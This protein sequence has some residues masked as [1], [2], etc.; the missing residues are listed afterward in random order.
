MRIAIV[1]HHLRPGG[2]TRVIESAVLSLQPKGHDIVVLVGEACPQSSP[3]ADH[4]RVV[5][6]L[7]YGASVTSQ[8]LSQRLKDAAGEVDCWHFHNH[9]LG[10]NVAL[11]DAIAAL[12]EDGTRI[13]LQ[14]HDFAEDGRPANYTVAAQSDVLYPS[15]EGVHYA[16]LTG[17]DRSILTY[18]GV[19][20]ERLHLL[21][22]PVMNSLPK[23]ISDDDKVKVGGRLFLYPTRGIRRKNIGEAVFLA[24]LLKGEGVQIATSRAPL[25]PV[26]L[27]THQ[28]W[29]QFASER[30]LPIAFAVVDNPAHGEHSYESW[31]S[32]A[33]GILTTSIAEGFGLAFLEPLLLE[34]PVIGRDLLEVTT[35]FRKVGLKM[36]GLYQ[37]LLVPEGWVD[38][39]AVRDRLQELL[40]PH[41]AAYGMKF[42][43]SMVAR[44]FE[45]IS[46]LSR[47][48]DFGALE[49]PFQEAVIQQ[50]VDDPESVDDVRTMDVD[51]VLSPAI[52]WLRKRM[53]MG[54]DLTATTRSILDGVFSLASYSDQLD[55]CY[56][57]MA[58]DCG[59]CAYVDS[60]AILNVFLAPERF[61]FLKS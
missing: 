46:P 53:D 51:R 20:E 28:R 12:A 11:P 23:E 4:V 9:S 36:S 3:I 26:W 58:G 17:R 48:I 47:W 2:V 22:N 8:E 37:A 59:S 31:L 13:L 38:V 35:D 27:K 56:L 25:N 21:P 50:L 39:D 33:R 24:A 6:G 29:E 57:H 54:G 34:K 19:P 41:F 5:E 14:I 32:A 61:H 52:P 40:P 18:A 30:E 42:S 10:K 43:E 15:K 44:A 49:E 45:V 16:V 55:R 1:H 7:G 60:T